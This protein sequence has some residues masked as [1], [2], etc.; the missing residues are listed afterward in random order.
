MYTNKN[1]VYSDDIFLESDIFNS[2]KISE[3][4]KIIEYSIQE[5]LTSASKHI[6]K[7]D[8][9]DRIINNEYLF[10]LSC[11]HTRE[12]FLYKVSLTEKNEDGVIKA[13]PIIETI[14]KGSLGIIGLKV[15]NDE[16]NQ[17]YIISLQNISKTSFHMLKLFEKIVDRCR[18]QGNY[19]VSKPIIY[20]RYNGKLVKTLHI[21]KDGD[22]V[23][24]DEDE[25]PLRFINKDKEES[26]HDYPNFK[27]GEF[28][29]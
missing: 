4:T 19:S 10:S 16:L 5:A 28:D 22:W 13:V 17:E 20:K 27:F 24:L 21:T 25:T 9:W 3:L 11:P 2:I 14:P 23:K 12:N 6:L 18:D 15:F 8:D 29:F 7:D 26:L 1:H